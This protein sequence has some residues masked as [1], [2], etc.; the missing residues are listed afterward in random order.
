MKWI[1]VE[2]ELPEPGET[3]LVTGKGFFNNYESSVQRWERAID[4][5]HKD[6]EPHW[7][8]T[9]E[10]EPYEHFKITHWMP[11]PKP[12]KETKKITIDG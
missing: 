3:V 7:F 2:F 9:R 4:P 11:L 1:D 5:N 12:P 6:D 10:M 8:G